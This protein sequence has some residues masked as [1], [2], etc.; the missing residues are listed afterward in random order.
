MSNS[1]SVAVAAVAT[2]EA[3]AATLDASRRTCFYYSRVRSY[4]SNWNDTGTSSTS[5]Q[6][7][8]YQP[9]TQ[10][11]EK[12]FLY[13]AYGSNL[14]AETFRG[15]RNIKPLSAINVVV[16]ELALVFNLPGLPYTEP[17]FANTRMRPDSSL[18]LEKAHLLRSSDLENDYSVNKS[19]WN[20]GLVGT[21]Y[22]VTAKDYAHIIATEGA[23]NAYADILVECFPLANEADEVPS[24][25]SGESFKAHTLYAGTLKGISNRRDGWAEPSPR[26]LNLITTGAKENKL[27]VEYR[28]WLDG[29]RPYRVTTRKQKIGQGI[30][31]ATW[32]PWIMLVFQLQAM[33]AGEDGRAPSWVGILSTRLM[34]LA[35]VSYDTVYRRIF[36]EGERTI[37]DEYLP[38]R[39]ER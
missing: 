32:L 13:L 14:S 6:L 23:G 24:S 2:T 17:A 15:K 4:F 7:P 33:L 20:K 28:E 16:P 19:G 38:P 22:E 29:L 21:V 37:G 36:G 3:S 31:L 34:S 39:I 8:A 26:Y 25:P 27:P 12:T 5:D 18:L 35:W 9:N 10:S 30:F 1:A 11:K